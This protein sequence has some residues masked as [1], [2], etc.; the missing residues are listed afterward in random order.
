MKNIGVITGDI[1]GSREISA[2]SREK[3]YL[4]FKKI[5]RQFTKK[6][7]D[8]PLRGIQGR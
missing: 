3:L 2:K 7:L 6:Q 4:D 1:V 5:F 8:K